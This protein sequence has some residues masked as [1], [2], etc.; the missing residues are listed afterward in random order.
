MSESLQLDCTVTCSRCKVA[1]SS[2]DFHRDA[3][4][5]NGLCSK[6]KDCFKTYRTDNLND[7][8]AYR[9]RY[10]ARSDKVAAREAKLAWDRANPD[11][12]AEAQRRYV[13]KNRDKVRS[14]KLI[15]EEK[16]REQRAAARK[17]HMR[18]NLHVHRARSAA[19]Q[20]A[21]IRATPSWA[22]KFLIEEAYHLAR[23]RT[24]LF[25]FPWHVDHIV[26]LRSDLVCGLHVEFNLAV[27]PGSLNMKKQNRFWPEMP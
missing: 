4:K 1:K 13:A 8:K 5:S 23:L 15:Y 2:A 24:M 19:R 18:E 12:T 21:K 20:A 9:K 7:I 22:N 17:K 25:G 11:K 27:I 14:A 16:T 6:C 3:R 26:P 10:Y